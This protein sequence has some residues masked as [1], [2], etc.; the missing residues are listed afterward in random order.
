[1]PEPLVELRPSVSCCGLLLSDMS[2][3]LFGGR[4]AA[5]CSESRIFKS[6]GYNYTF[7]EA[8][9]VGKAVTINISLLILNAS[10]FILLSIAPQ[11]AEG[12]I[13]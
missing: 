5:V 2:I 8:S 3:R 7:R 13:S 9:I 12:V 6:R 1:M 11:R 4:L 10:R